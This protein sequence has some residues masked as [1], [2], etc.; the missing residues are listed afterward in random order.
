M[1]TSEVAFTMGRVNP[2]PPWEML[3]FSLRYNNKII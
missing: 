1:N 2:F 3:L